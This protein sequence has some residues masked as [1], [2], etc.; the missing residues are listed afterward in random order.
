MLSNIVITPEAIAEFVFEKTIDMLC[1]DI[2]R[3]A[4]S[5]ELAQFINLEYT[6][7]YHFYAYTTQ[8]FLLL[9]KSKIAIATEYANSESVQIV[10]KRGIKQFE[11]WFKQIIANFD[12]VA[13]AHIITLPN[14]SA[15]SHYYFTNNQKSTP[16]IHL[17]INRNDESN[18]FYI[19]DS[20]LCKKPNFAKRIEIKWDRIIPIRVTT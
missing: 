5:V 1:N 17:L 19:C 3:S 12:N 7:A 14:L 18:E 16:L 11:L 6:H 4:E 10:E 13:D 2:L 20:L 8:D 9:N 15:K